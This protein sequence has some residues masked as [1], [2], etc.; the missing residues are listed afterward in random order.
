MYRLLEP[1]LC[2][3]DDSSTEAHTQW[4]YLQCLC[5]IETAIDLADCAFN[6]DTI[7]VLERNSRKACI[8]Q[9]R[10]REINCVVS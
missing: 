1:I 9:E 6:K 4:A 8:L 5:E 3:T 2:I 10:E 7:E